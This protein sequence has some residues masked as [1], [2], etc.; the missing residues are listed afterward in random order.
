MEQINY[1]NFFVLNIPKFEIMELE[2]SLH[3]DNESDDIY[4]LQG[5]IKESNIKNL[6]SSVKEAS[7]RN[8]ETEPLGAEALPMLELIVGLAGSAGVV[9]LI[10]GLFDCIKSYIIH[11]AKA[12]EVILK[13]GDLTIVFN[14]ETIRDLQSLV[15]KFIDSSEGIK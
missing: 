2:L 12:K 6:S 10:N 4:E 9:A 15:N 3:S 5:W 13:K 14:S 11:N 1:T 8:G 7:Q